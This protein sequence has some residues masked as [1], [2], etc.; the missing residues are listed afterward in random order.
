[1]QLDLARLGCLAGDLHEPKQVSCADIVRIIR[2]AYVWL[3][4]NDAVA[5]AGVGKPVHKFIGTKV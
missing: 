3:C 4:E 5:G 1:V 2:R